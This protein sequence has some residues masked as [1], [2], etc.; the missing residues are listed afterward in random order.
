MLDPE[1]PE[2]THGYE[3]ED[4][5]KA[6]AQA[7]AHLVS[8]AKRQDWETYGEL[9]KEID[10][11]SFAPNDFALAA[12]LGQISREEYYAGR[13]ML[14]AIVVHKYGDKMPGKGFYKLAR[15]LGLDISDKEAL[16]VSE[17][18]KVWNYWKNQRG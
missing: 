10:A 11:I 16:W 13:G 6:K 7:T 4:W 1:N 9:V 2:S 14:T 3:P 12:L 5:Q 17:T 15:Y 8:V 18:K